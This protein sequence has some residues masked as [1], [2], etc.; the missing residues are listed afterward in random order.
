MRTN[1]KAKR[2]ISREEFYEKKNVKKGLPIQNKER[3]QN[4]IRDFFPLFL[5]NHG[6]KFVDLKN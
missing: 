1:E 6:G 5:Q 4:K 3:F 2:K